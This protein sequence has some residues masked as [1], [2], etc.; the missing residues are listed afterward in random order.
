MP[1]LADYVLPAG[2]VA[3]HGFVLKPPAALGASFTVTVPG[4]DASGAHVFEVRHWSARGLTLPAEGDL[5][6]VLVDDAEDAWAISWWPSAGDVALREATTHPHDF[7]LV[8]ALPTK[9]PTP[10][11]GDTC[12]FETGVAGVIWHLIYTGEATYPWAKIGGAPLYASSAEGTPL[13]NS[14]E[15]PVI[16][17][18]ITTPLAIDGRFAAGANRAIP[19]SGA[20]AA[21]SLYFGSTGKESAIA[22]PTAQ[23]TP[24]VKLAGT[25]PK[26]TVVANKYSRISG[27]GTIEFVGLWLEIN[28]IRVG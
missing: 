2:A 6:L 3:R 22:G 13:T 9:E 21:V 15:T 19:P 1:L 27:T 11:K 10:A 28:P 4:F 7:G 25:T 12:K 23:S 26:G 8:T 20:L 5:V 17:A 24:I 18:S 14:T 16:G